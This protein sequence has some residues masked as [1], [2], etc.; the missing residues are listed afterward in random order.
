MFEITPKDISHLDDRQLRTLV[1][2]LC[3][4]EL[5]RR[6]DS[7]VAVTWG[8]NQNAADGG[9]DVRKHTKTSTRSQ[10]AREADCGY[11]CGA[12]HEQAAY[13]KASS[14]FDQGRRTAPCA[15]GRGV[16][17]PS[18]NAAVVRKL[19]RRLYGGGQQNADR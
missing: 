15:G 12:G 14:E 11:E 1:G 10:P 13:G 7:V 19:A 17:R 8:G 5:R 18:L 3:E 9:L 6:G 2:L 4:A 16:L